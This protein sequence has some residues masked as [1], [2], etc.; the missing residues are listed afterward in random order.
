M[1]KEETL[2]GIILFA[3]YEEKFAMLSDEDK[4]GLIMAMF[5]Y[6][7]TGIVSEGLSPL[8]QFAL[9]FIKGDIDRN[10]EKYEETCKRNRENGKKGGRPPKQVSAETGHEPEGDSE[11]QAGHADNPVGFSEY[12]AFFSESQNNPEKPKEKY[13]EKEKYNP[14]E[15]EKE[16]APAVTTQAW[17]TPTQER[18]QIPSLEEVTAYCR[19]IQST[20]TPQAFY[21]YYSSTGWM[22]NGRAI[23]DWKAKLRYWDT[24]D[25][26]KGK[27]TATVNTPGYEDNEEYYK[28]IFSD[29]E[30]SNV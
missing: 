28:L 5:A 27:T 6:N 15:S 17:D 12:P 29:Y 3:D 4:A 14:K 10:R 23:P 2:P 1:T 11:N 30:R 22:A 13:K 20:V 25:R 7:R 19:E 21:D 24:K 26:E 16:N 9:S 18:S 8:V